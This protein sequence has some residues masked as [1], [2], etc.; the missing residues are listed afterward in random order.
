VRA[1]VEVDQTVGMKCLDAGLALK[2]E[3]KDKC[4]VQICAFAQDHIYSQDDSGKEMLQIIKEAASQMRRRC[5][6][7]H[8][9]Y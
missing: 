3:F 1:F 2:Q 5:Y 8:A 7:K 6:R 4:R 9:V